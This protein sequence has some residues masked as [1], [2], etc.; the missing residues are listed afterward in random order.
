MSHDAT[1]P[2][3]ANDLAVRVVRVDVVSG[4]NAGASR[5]ADADS[6]RIGTAEGNDLVLSDPTV[7]R[8]HLELRRGRGRIQVVDLGSGLLPHIFS[9]RSASTR[10]AVKDGQTIVIGGLIKD[11]TSKTIRKVPLLGDIPLVGELFKRTQESKSKT[12][13]LIFL[14]PHVAKQPQDLTGISNTEEQ[15]SSLSKDKEA[16]EVYRRHM[17]AMRNENLEPNRP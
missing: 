5:V 3:R 16:A 15:R 13:L 9:T 4:P 10:V 8:F 7:S 11:Q 6:L 14:T 17:E 2:L 1:V 12:E